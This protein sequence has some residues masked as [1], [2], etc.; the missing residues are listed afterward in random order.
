VSPDKGDGCSSTCK[1]E[2]VCGDGKR[3][4]PEQ[5]D[6]GQLPPMSGDGCSSTCKWEYC[7]NGIL[8]P[9][10]Q[11]ENTPGN[12]VSG[13]GCSSTCTYEP[14]CGDGVKAGSEQCDEGGTCSVSGATCV[15]TR[16]DQ[17]PQSSCPS[18]Q[19]CKAAAKNSCNNKCQLI[20]S[21]GDGIVQ[22]PGEKCDP[23]HPTNGPDCRSDCSGNVVVH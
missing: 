8:D 19:T 6:D 4:N 5:C 20:A 22:A 2:T 13:D 21:C 9:G 18:G 11:C 12:N 10:E 1:L 17:N 23:A 14:V 7:G 3:E 16:F 15:V